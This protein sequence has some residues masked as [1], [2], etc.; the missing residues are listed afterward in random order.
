MSH[1]QDLISQVQELDPQLGEDLKTE[2]KHLQSRRSFGLT[3]ERHQPE[4]VELPGRPIRKGD[5]VHIRPKRGTPKPAKIQLWLVTGIEEHGDG[6]VANLYEILPNNLKWNIER[7]GREPETTAVP[8]DELVAVAEFRDR[9][10][11]GLEEV[12]RLGYGKCLDPHHVIINSENYH[13]LELLTYT[14]REAIDLCYIDPPYN[15]GGKFSWLYNDDYVD[16]N[17]QYRHSKWLAFMERRLLLAWELLKPT[18]AIFISIGDEEQAHLRMLMD[19][20]F[21]SN[22]MIAQ[23]AIEMSTTS[24][25]KTTNAQQG[26]IVKN[27]EYV[28]IYRKSAAFNKEIEQTPLYDAVQGW[29]HH[30]S[31][32]LFED[33]TI[34]NFYEQLSSEPRVKA[35]ME[36]A[37]LFDKRGKFSGA[38]NMDKLLAFSEAANEFIAVHLNQIARKDTPPVTAQNIEVSA[39]HWVELKTPER[40]YKITRLSSGTLNQLYTLDR[41]YRQVEGEGTQAARTV[42]RGDLWKGFHKDMGN[43]HNE[44][45]INFAN[46][47]KPTRLIRQLIR[48]A[49]NRPDTVTLDFFGGSGTTSHAVAQMNAADGGNRRSILVTN[50]EVGPAEQ[51][52]L[53][54]KGLRPGDSDWEDKGVFEAVTKT[55]IS[56]IAEET[57]AN[58][59]FFKLT[60]ENPI[61]IEYGQAFNQIAPMLWLRAGQ[62]GRVISTLPEWGWDV[63]ENYAVIEDTDQSRAFCEAVEQAVGVRMVFIITNDQLTYQQICRSL[64]AHIDKV[65]LYESYLDNFSIN[66]REH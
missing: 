61:L 30:Y 64:P 22:N 16:N 28:L 40:T 35:D 55:R 66:Y 3:F 51:R 37:R 20:I 6:R 31:L 54:K 4:S 9:I 12:G 24:G 8:V 32:W 5:K 62:V 59:A 19:Q 47:K 60:Y 53:V 43:V 50:N 56:N 46:G 26:T 2:L 13:A 17:D 45:K 27:T 65:R 15:T 33:G 57:N 48:W 63:A 58:V 23:L 10:F 14:H 34:G 38:K 18:G 41:N 49:N 42:I 11:P 21:G 1:I 44:G 39:D 7:I 36:A 52:K 25:P 29:D